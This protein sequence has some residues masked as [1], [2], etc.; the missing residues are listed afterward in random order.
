MSEHYSLMPRGLQSLVLNSIMHVFAW[1]SEIP[2]FFYKLSLTRKD[3]LM[4]K[5][6]IVIKTS[7]FDSE[8]ILKA[9][10]FSGSL[11]VLSLTSIALEVDAIL[12]TLLIGILTFWLQILY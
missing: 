3:T 9:N 2:N 5:M 11:A 7:R 10:L 8:G 4:A 1:L 6:M 12:D